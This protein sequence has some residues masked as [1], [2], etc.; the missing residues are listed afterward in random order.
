MP[1]CTE[2]SVQVQVQFCEA[3]ILIP[4]V[5]LSKT[6]IC[7]SVFPSREAHVH[8][9][10]LSP[11]S[12]ANAGEG[13]RP[14]IEQMQQFDGVLHV[15]QFPC[16][17]ALKHTRLNSTAPPVTT[18]APCS[19][20][21][22]GNWT[23]LARGT[24]RQP[25]RSLVGKTKKMLTQGKPLIVAQAQQ[26]PN[27]ESV[28]FHD[29]F[30]KSSP[31]FRLISQSGWLHVACGTI[32]CDTDCCGRSPRPRSVTSSIGRRLQTSFLS[33]SVENEYLH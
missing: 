2:Y 20:G 5:S 27:P 31:I 23:F 26:K 3:S 7:V 12:W 11:Y 15:G 33:R 18:Q 17:C 30:L 14:C 9:P 25:K 19:S 21:F 32:E 24:S 1:I 22:W 4:H 10:Y 29:R 16:C 28:S 13:N 8:I 6:S